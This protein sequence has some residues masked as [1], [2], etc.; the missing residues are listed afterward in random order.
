MSFVGSSERRPLP[1]TPVPR[2]PTLVRLAAR[3]L[4]TVLCAPPQ[5]NGMPPV[6]LPMRARRQQSGQSCPA[7]RPPTHRT[8]LG[9]R[10]STFRVGA[11]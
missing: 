5:T 6:R 10:P 4:T 8:P 9:T 11:R 2:N 3:S 1:P 7:S